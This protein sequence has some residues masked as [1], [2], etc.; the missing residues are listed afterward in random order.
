M[1]HLFFLLSNL[2]IWGKKGSAQEQHKDLGEKWYSSSPVCSVYIDFYIA[3]VLLICLIYL[4]C[5]AIKMFGP[6]Q[7]WQRWQQ[8]ADADGQIAV[9]GRN[10]L[11]R[12]RR[13]VPDRTN[14]FTAMTDT[15]FVE[16]FRLRKES[17]NDIIVKIQDHLPHSTDK[18][19]MQ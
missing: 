2:F 8:F 12:E 19:G 16:R 5:R 14:P 13:V 3:F 15:E 18:R 1:I 9:A 11:R 17:V 4:F 7:Q 6:W 10:G